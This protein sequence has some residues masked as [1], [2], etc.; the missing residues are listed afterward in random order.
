MKTFFIHERIHKIYFLFTSFASFPWLLLK[1]VLQNNKKTNQE[2]GRQEIQQSRY[3]KVSKA[4]KY[5]RESKRIQRG[6]V[7]GIK[8]MIIR[9]STG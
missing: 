5:R 3:T 9:E 8:G 7:K 4:C 1:D 2:R 6:G